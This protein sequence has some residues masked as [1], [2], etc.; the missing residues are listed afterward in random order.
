[1]D[2]ATDIHVVLQML[3]GLP[4]PLYSYHELMLTEAG[5]E[6]LSKSKG[7]PALRDLRAAGW[8]ARMC[9]RWVRG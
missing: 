6:K 8:T 5:D 3:L 9:G 2:A 1:M 4:S 7:S